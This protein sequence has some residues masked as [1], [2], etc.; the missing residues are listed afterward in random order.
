MR[1]YCNEQS[2]SENV[3]PQLAKL[4]PSL[5]DSRRKACARTHM[6]H[7]PMTLTGR[8]GL[9]LRL[10]YCLGLHA[11]CAAPALGTLGHML[12]RLSLHTAAALRTSM[13]PS[14]RKPGGE[15]RIPFIKCQA[16]P[17]TA[18]MPKAP[19]MSSM[20]RSGHGSRWCS[21][22]PDC[23]WAILLLLP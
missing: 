17:P 3:R 8:T 18:P 13:A 16:P 9:G 19:P 10:A 15:L 11:C 20:M 14:M 1:R 5:G 21:T 23:C 4:P 12:K 2:K 6:P 22:C 7:R